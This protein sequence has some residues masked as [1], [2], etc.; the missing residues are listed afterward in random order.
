MGD[1]LLIGGGGRDRFFLRE[2]EGLD[3]IRGFRL[4]QDIL[5]FRGIRPSDVDFFQDGNDTII[6]FGDED[7]AIV[8]NTDAL[9]LEF[10]FG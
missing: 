2:G 10:F 3:T 8:K 5:K 1:D 6:G 9:D 4:D 7:L